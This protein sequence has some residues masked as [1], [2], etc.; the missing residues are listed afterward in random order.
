MTRYRYVILGS[1]RQGTAAAYDLALRGD[2]REIVLADASDERARQAVS[3]VSSRLPSDHP[4]QVTPK[5]VNGGNADSVLALL[6]NTDAAISALP[7]RYNL[8]I[9]RYAIQARCH[10]CDLGGHPDTTTAQL[11]LNDSARRARV[12]VV[13]D[14]GQA[15]GMTTSLMALALSMVPS[16]ENLEV[17]NGGL[18]LDPSPPLFYRL[19]FAVQGLTN[20]YDGP[21]YNL[22]DGK[23]VALESLSEVQTVDFPRPLGR[24]E[25]FCASGTGSTFPWTYRGK[26]RQFTSRIVRYPGHLDVIR[27]LKRLGFFSEKPLTVDGCVVSPRRMTET[28]LE[29]LLMGD[30]PIQ[31]VV[32]VRVHCTGRAKRRPVR[33]EVD[34]LVHHDPK[35]GLTAMQ[36]CTGF[37]AAIV[38]AMMASGEIAPGV[39]VRELSVD[40]E[41][42]LAELARRGL[43]VTRRVRDLTAA[44]A[45]KSPRRGKQ[46]GRRRR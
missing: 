33:A 1:G 45:S 31:D 16:P 32:V 26:L 7:Y 5:P 34:A 25:A 6:R 12:S 35:T 23:V 22:R 41:R 18:P 9:T 2:A 29:P 3:W 42:Y 36:R 38:A 13:P 43:E 24:L 20:Q 4:V 27:T 30:S 39:A 40:P 46:T 15:P 37:D 44:R 19:T 21:C 14:C 10:L 28:L 17:W 11:E 8:D